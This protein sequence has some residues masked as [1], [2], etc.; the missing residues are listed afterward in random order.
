MAAMSV[1]RHSH[2]MNL[3]KPRIN[4]ITLVNLLGP[5]IY[6]LKILANEYSVVS[7]KGKPHFV[8]PATGKLPKLYVVSCDSA[9][10]YVGV[11]R[12]SLSTRFRGGM[13]ASGEDGYYGYAWSKTDRDLRL[14]IWYLDGAPEDSISV[15]LETIEAE[16]VYLFR[17]E[18][19]Q[20]PSDQTEIHFHRSTGFHRMSAQRVLGKLKE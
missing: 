8:R 3:K 7:P 13:Q 5:D 10:L 20:W 4:D 2:C 16:V 9:L 18:S 1:I 11:S 15:E 6:K 17:L 14:D 12:Q 19:G